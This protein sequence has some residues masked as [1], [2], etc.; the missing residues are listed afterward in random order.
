VE[1]NRTMMCASLSPPPGVIPA[2]PS[3]EPGQTN[4]ER[5]DA[6][7]WRATRFS[8][9]WRERLALVVDSCRVACLPPV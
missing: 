6:H 7:T 3:V 8:D 5:V 9:R 1:I 2:L 4:R